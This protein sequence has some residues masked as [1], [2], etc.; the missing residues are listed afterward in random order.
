[1]LRWQ[2]GF[3][4]KLY[5]CFIIIESSHHIYI[6]IYIYRR[7]LR[8]LWWEHTATS[9]QSLT[10]NWKFIF[11]ESCGIQLFQAGLSNFCKRF[12]TRRY[13][14]FCFLLLFLLLLFFFYFCFL[15]LKSWNMWGMSTRITFTIWNHCLLFSHIYH[16]SV[17][18]NQ[19]LGWFDQTLGRPLQTLFYKK[20]VFSKNHTKGPLA[21][22]SYV[23]IFCRHQFTQARKWEKFL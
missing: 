11:Y 6:Y 2:T 1:M 3:A 13:L 20:Y 5:N 14:W 23:F 15:M 8:V 4:T 7:L 19:I 16:L 21:L 10:G 22:T 12:I 17:T 18:G 9:P